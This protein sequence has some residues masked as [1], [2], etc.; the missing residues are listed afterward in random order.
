M[1]YIVANSQTQ[2]NDFH[3]LT[4]MAESKKALFS[5]LLKTQNFL[6]YHWLGGKGE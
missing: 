1:D 3:S 6:A 2:L 4:L 5:F